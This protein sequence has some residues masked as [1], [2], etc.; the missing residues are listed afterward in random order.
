M[1]AALLFGLLGAAVLMWLGFWQLERLHWKE[2]I[3]AEIEARIMADPVALPAV[4]DPVAHRYL[5]VVASGTLSGVVQVLAST[6]DYGPGYRIIQGFE[7]DGR[8]VLV[9]RGFR[10]IEEHSDVFG[11][12]EVTVIGNLYWPDEVDRFTPEPDR[13]RNLWFARDVP[14]IAQVLG[15]E[16]VLIV[17][18]EVT[19]LLGPV[20]PLPI[21]AAGIP[22]RHLEYV[23]TWFSLA[24]VWLGMTAYLMWRI[25]R[26]TD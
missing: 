18:R 24:I 19:P 10:P 9:D 21:D 14:A 7:T 1:I 4:P 11:P 13:A 2:G 15:T 26:G 12:V 16:P 20:Y 8:R 5:P 22:N 23:V 25:R 3:L 17:A 6:R